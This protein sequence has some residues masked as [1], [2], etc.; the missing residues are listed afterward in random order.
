MAAPGRNRFTG[1]DLR[2]MFRALDRS[3]RVVAPRPIHHTSKLP[4]ARD[5]AGR[6]MYVAGVSNALYYSNGT[7][8][9][10]L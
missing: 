10:A 3:S 9:T 6:V 2:N 5:N 1:S 8:W 7:T 4:P